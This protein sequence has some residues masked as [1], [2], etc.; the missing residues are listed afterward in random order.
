MDSLKDELNEDSYYID[1]ITRLRK[2]RNAVILA[3]NYQRG[4][5]QDIADY[6]GDSL[7][8][9]QQAAKTDADII[10]FCGVFF[11]AETA[12]I[13]SPQKTVIIPDPRAGCPMADMITA[14]DLRQKKQEHPEATVVCYVNS[15]ADVKAESDI[16][17]TSTNAIQVVESLKD[18]KEI[19]FVPDEHL[20]R[21]VA[22]R[23]KADILFWPGFCPTHLRVTPEDIIKAREEHPN[24]KCIVHPECSIE[25]I[26]LA[27]EALSTGGIIKYVGKSDAGEIIIG[28]ELGLAYRL[29]KDHPHKRFYL[30][31]QKLVCPNMKLTTLEKVAAALENIQHVVKVPENIRVRAKLALDRMMEI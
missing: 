26:M 6:V 28:T 2:E 7:G 13:L 25:V 23:T 30:A 1:L 9:S 4:E 31:T 27:D 24:A 18:A 19:L 14:E 21:F 20:G 29:Q 10:V 12:A 3:H 22:S 8:L 16:C 11:M 5:V 17:C 15:S